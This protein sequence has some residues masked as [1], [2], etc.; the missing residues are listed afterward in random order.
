V[1]YGAADSVDGIVRR[2]RAEWP[3]GGS[4]YTVAT[5]GLASKVVPFTKEIQAVE[6]YLTLLGLKIVAT[7]LGLKW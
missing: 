5:G 1:L 6:P 4:P 2:I 7:H 3:G